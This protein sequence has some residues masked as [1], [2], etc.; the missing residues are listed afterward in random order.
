MRFSQF[1]LPTLRED[2]ADAEIVSH[3]MMFR[4]GMIRKV[5]SGIYAFLPLGWKVYRKVEAI[6][7]EEMNRAGAL[8]VF[9]PAVHPAELWQETGRWQEYGKEL[10]RMTDRHDRSYCFGPT[11]EEV[12]TDLARRE[13]R[14]YR[15]MPVNFYQI[16]VK[17]RDEIRPR[18]GVMR[19]R[20]FIMKDAYSFDVDE[21][22]SDASYWKMYEAYRR[23][24]TRCGLTFR[25]VEAESGLIGGS[26]SHEFMALAAIG[27]E[28][29]ASCTACDY[30]ANVKKAEIFVPDESS[31][32]AEEG[33]PMERIA[34]PDIKTI[35]ALADFLKTR[36]ENLV[37]TLI[38]ESEKGLVAAL[39][40]GD[41]DVNEIKLMTVL[42]AT[43]AE[44]AG[45]DVVE[46][47]TRSPKGF[48]GPVGLQ[49]PILA[50][51][52]LRNMANLVT[53]GNEKDFHLINVNVNRDFKVDRFVDIRMA[54]EGDGCPRCGEP[55]R[56]DRG[57]EVGQV[58]KLGKK[59]SEAMKASYLDDQGNERAIV[60]GCYG[61]GLARTMAAIIEQHHD[62]D[63]TIF[64]MSVAPFHVSIVPV[65][66]KNRDLM[67]TAER[68]ALDLEQKGIEPLFDDRSER[69]GVKFKDADLIGIPLRVTLGERNFVK[70][71]LEIRSRETGETS[72]VRIDRAVR[73]LTEKVHGALKSTLPD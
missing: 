46:R 7:R 22:A 6:I 70:D 39:V 48:A 12:I 73:I 3:K 68:I 16:Q 2:P 35:D 54:A 53:G 42:D 58:F 71:Q 11:H 47:V 14:S 32:G 31:P 30:S 43:R 20:E 59:Y 37:K 26:F 67:E 44:L 10:L 65:N 40:R 38:F 34:T 4:T 9:L 61:I 23:I 24:F 66:D 13:I 60:M 28:T 56:F 45:D 49:I 18:F 25:P 15:Q 63:G 52:A 19:A 36:H 69:P 50:D 5:S 62:K 55:F 33:K 41:H 21:K 51:H 27:E 8:E 17:F 57:I 72:V 1:Y 64:P 29:I